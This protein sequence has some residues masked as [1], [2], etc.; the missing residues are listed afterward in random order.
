MSDNDDNIVEEQILPLA[1][2]SRF[3]FVLNQE[4]DCMICKYYID[5]KKYGGPGKLKK[6]CISKLNQRKRKLNDDMVPMS[7]RLIQRTNV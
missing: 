6:A 3:E 5:K 2:S 4:A 7:T 1:E